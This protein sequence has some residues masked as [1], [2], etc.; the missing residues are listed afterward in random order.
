[1]PLFM[2]IGETAGFVVPCRSGGCVVGL[3]RTLSHLDWATKKV[4]EWAKVE[5][6]GTKNRFNDGKCDAMGRVWAG[7]YTI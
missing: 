1:M 5:L 6:K 7:T 4:Q 2:N 3:G